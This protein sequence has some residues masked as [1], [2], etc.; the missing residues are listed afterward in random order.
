[1]LEK[2]EAKSAVVQIGREGE[3]M[4]YTPVAM[5]R[6]EHKK[7]WNQNAAVIM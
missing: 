5:K 1:M 4:V 3:T 7:T 2:H 6:V